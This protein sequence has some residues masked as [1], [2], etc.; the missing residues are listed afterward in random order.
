MNAN[1]EIIRDYM[2]AVDFRLIPMIKSIRNENSTPLEVLSE[3]VPFVLDQYSRLVLNKNIPF[4]EVIKGS[5]IYLEQFSD[6]ELIEMKGCNKIPGPDGE[7]DD[8]IQL[9]RE[10]I[11]FELERRKKYV[12]GKRKKGLIELKNTVLSKIPLRGWGL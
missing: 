1:I 12:K 3:E 7:E 8:M 11:G 10:W 4:Y 2:L 9:M 5:F 6:K